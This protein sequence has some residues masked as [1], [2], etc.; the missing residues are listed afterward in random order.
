MYESL[1]GIEANRTLEQAYEHTRS[2]WFPADPVIVNQVR[3]RIENGYYRQNRAALAADLRQDIS[4]YL[5]CL[6]D[7]RGMVRGVSSKRRPEAGKQENSKLSSDDAVLRSIANVIDLRG[8]TLSAHSL[9]DMS[10]L[11]TLRLRESVLSSTAARCLSEK[12]QFNP[13]I[14]YSCALLR[15]LGLTLIA[16]N[17]PKVY[18]QAVQSLAASDK[19]RSRELDMTLHSV[20]GFSPTMLGVKFARSWHISNEVVSTLNISSHEA[21][22][23]G[24]TTHSFDNA[25]SLQST[26]LAHLCSIGEALARANNPQLYPSARE[27][28]DGAQRLIKRHLGREGVYAIYKRVNEV[29][30]HYAQQC[31]AVITRVLC[32]APP[33]GISD[34]L[35]SLFERNVYIKT[36]SPD[37]QN[38]FAKLYAKIPASKVSEELIRKLLH[39]ITCKMGFESSSVFMLDPTAVSL[40]P[41]SKVGNPS[42]VKLRAISLL[43][44][45]S[46]INPIREAFTNSRPFLEQG[47]LKDGTQHAFVV[48]AIGGARP[49]GVLY[50]EL[51]KN[52]PAEIRSYPLT[53]FRAVVTCL[54]DLLHL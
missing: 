49:V 30:A 1:Q 38:D 13:D 32:P 33:S 4:L 19:A 15:Q 5:L 39:E 54:N 50:L 37:I 22:H 48:G 51:A 20:L 24:L 27:D 8:D 11:Q 31:P 34:N 43:D 2:A 14:V 7:L 53:A 47:L 25:N 12:L 21:L 9:R 17:Y 26:D 52:A 29:C 18:E 16:W 6:K 44:S 45:S 36:C 40:L 42:F 28:W 23:Q 10:E 35:R 41:V 3:S 46:H